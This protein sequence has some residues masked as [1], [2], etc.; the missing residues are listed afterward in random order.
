MS[1]HESRLPGD[2]GKGA[3]PDHAA[4]K[5]PWEK[6]VSFHDA[7][8]YANRHNAAMGTGF[9]E[10]LR[11]VIPD[12]ETR[13]KRL[14][15]ASYRAMHKMFSTSF[16]KAH[17]D[18][19]NFHPFIKGG[20]HTALF[21]DSGDERL[22]MCG[23]VNDFGPYRAEKELDT[24]DWDIVGSEVCRTSAVIMGAIGD[25]YADVDGGPPMEYNF[26]E[27][28]GVG[29]L[30]CRAVGENREKY[31]MPEKE[32]WESLGPVATED[33]IKF[34]P[35]EKMYTEPQI[36]R[37]DSDYKYRNGLCTEWT[38]AELYLK[39]G[40]AGTTST[41]YVNFLLDEMVENGEITNEEINSIITSVF[42]Y[43]G[44]MMFVEF[45]A[46]KGVRDW[47]GVPDGID[48]GRVLGG[49]LEVLFQ[50]LRA[51]YTVIEFDEEGACYDINLAAI[52][53]RFPRL[54]DAYVAMWYGMCRT[55]VN[56]LWFSWR[57]TE[58]VPEDILRIKIGKKI[59]KRCI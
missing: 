42:N 39:G 26:F 19:H 46:K 30:H 13:C 5:T 28:R 32:I 9:M 1:N 22:W 33:Q 10:V 54:T 58:N 50:I 4:V 27:A 49:Y 23:R 44:K 2:I 55:L 8:R 6:L 59:D 12:Y 21:G 3:L 7:F 18:N 34:T 31:P 11:I 35:E 15:E 38:A 24:C 56:A 53:R 36:F 25:A 47:L 57:E 45:Y 14:C 29:D 41:D 52:E 51:D 20:C 40:N 17:A 16:G 37:N 48:D 43:A